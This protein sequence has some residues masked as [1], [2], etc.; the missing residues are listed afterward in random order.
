ME[1]ELSQRYGDAGGDNPDPTHPEQFTES[2]RGAFFVVYRDGRAIGCGGLRSRD[3]GTAEIKRMY[4]R[5]EWRGRGISREVL[6]ILE[7]R[8]IELGYDRI[9]LESG[10]AQ[11]EACSLYET[12][13]Y[14]RIE[15]YGVWKDSPDSVCYEKKLGTGP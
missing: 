6:R 5:P 15:P 13:E 14:S 3:A 1:D 7:D 2:E 8:A 9:I 12:S 11:P 10:T 4:V